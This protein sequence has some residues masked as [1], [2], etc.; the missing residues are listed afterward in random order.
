MVSTSM[1]GKSSAE[2]RDASVCGFNPVQDDRSDLTKN[3]LQTANSG[4]LTGC[5]VHK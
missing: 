2:T 3:E 1:V 5:L 4:L